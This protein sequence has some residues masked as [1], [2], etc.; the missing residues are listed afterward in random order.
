[1]PTV[2]ICYTLG[3]QAV[4]CDTITVFNY[5]KKSDCWYPSVIPGV[6]LLEAK[7]RSAT[8]TGT[9]NA[10]A[11][12]IIIRCT[13]G[14][15]ITTAA[16]AKRYVGLKEY[17]KSDTPEEF[18]TFTPECDFIYAGAWPE[19]EPLLDDDYDEGLYHAMNEGYDG[20][21]MISSTGFYGLL[22]HFEIGGR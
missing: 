16:G 6:D 17:A 5:H 4:Y 1:M 9:N 10:D 7:S 11:V 19:T 3:V 21:Y 13:P 22:P 20:V 12:D 18:I 2:S 8:A 15:E 14:K